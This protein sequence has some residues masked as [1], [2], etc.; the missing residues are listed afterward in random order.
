MIGISSIDLSS[1][2]GFS[3][4]KLLFSLFLFNFSRTVAYGLA[5]IVFGASS[6]FSAFGL[7]LTMRLLFETRRATFETRFGINVRL[8]ITFLLLELRKL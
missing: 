7:D 1:M 6:Y 4:I 2:T 8:A 3:A 5:A